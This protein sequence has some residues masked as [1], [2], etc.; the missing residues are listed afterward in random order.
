MRCLLL[1]A[2]ALTG[3]AAGQQ[4]QGE[5]RTIIVYGFYAE[6]V[7]A[8]TGAA[9]PTT[10]THTGDSTATVQP[11]ATGSAEATNAPQVDATVDV[12]PGL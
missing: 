12:T 9:L 10:L 5:T 7:D 1:A 6:R 3:C 2:L 8:L 11:A 4:G